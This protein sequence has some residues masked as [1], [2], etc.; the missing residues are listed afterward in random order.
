MNPIRLPRVAAKAKTFAET[1]TRTHSRCLELR[2]SEAG[3]VL[4][5]G[6]GHTLCR[7]TAPAPAGVVLG[8]VEPFLVD[9]RAFAKAAG[10]VG[11]GRTEPLVSAGPELVDHRDR[12]LTVAKLDAKTLGVAGP[13]G[14][15]KTL[16]VEPG[17]MPDSTR[18]FDGIRAEGRL[19]ARVDP[20]FLQSAADVAVAAGVTAIDVT[21]TPRLNFL[22]TAGTS[23]DGTIVEVA[24]AGIGEVVSQDAPRP[25]WELDQDDP[26][27]FTM[28]DSKPRK[29]APRKS[30]TQRPTLPL[31]DIPF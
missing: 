4:T 8:N 22:A 6:D 18:I 20:R 3:A 15:P 11:C 27:V 9:A 30:K 28:A 19:V 14:E 7:I 5:V 21:F 2:Q 16:D 25:A 23:R 29:A 10:D 13:E 17:T 26:L 1:E 31:D 24:V 12:P